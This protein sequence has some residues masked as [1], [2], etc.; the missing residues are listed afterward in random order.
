MGMFVDDADIDIDGLME[1]L[2]GPDLPTGAIIN[3]AEG[4]REAYHTDVAAYMCARAY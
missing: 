3:G 4:I 1:H 2:P